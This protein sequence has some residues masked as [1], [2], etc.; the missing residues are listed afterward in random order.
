MNSH[1]AD[2]AGKAMVSD[3][4]AVFTKDREKSGISPDMKTHLSAINCVIIIDEE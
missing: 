1:S 2:A 4:K 3:S